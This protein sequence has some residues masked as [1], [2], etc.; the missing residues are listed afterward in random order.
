MKAAKCLSSR[1]SVCA[2]V[3]FDS[4]SRY[5]GTSETDSTISLDGYCVRLEPDLMSCPFSQLASTRAK[6]IPNIRKLGRTEPGRL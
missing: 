3:P 4:F 5:E 1:R 2:L 6:A